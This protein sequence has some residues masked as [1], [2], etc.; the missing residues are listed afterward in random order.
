MA[1]PSDGASAS[2]AT[3]GQRIWD[4]VEAL[5][6]SI[7]RDEIA[8]ALGNTRPGG[9]GG[10]ALGAGGVAGSPI[11]ASLLV[12]TVTPKVPFPLLLDECYIQAD[13]A[14]TMAFDIWVQRP[15]QFAIDAASI[16]GGAPVQLV[17]SRETTLSP[18]VDGWA[19]RMIEA[20]S[21]VSLFVTSSDGLASSVT[22]TLSGKCV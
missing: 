8:R 4:R 7:A 1:N 22:L 9:A 13:I 21:V 3:K 18:I 19:T 16:L 14:C 11:L 5:A 12:P 6:R 10:L 15:G 2:G 17:A 20:G